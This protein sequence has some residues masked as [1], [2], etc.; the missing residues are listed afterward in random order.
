MKWGPVEGSFRLGDSVCARKDLTWALE[1]T[2]VLGVGTNARQY[3]VWSGNTIMYTH[4][5]SGT[6][7]MLGS[8]YRRWGAI[9]QI[10]SGSGS[11]RVAGKV[12]GTS[13][14]DN[15]AP[16]VNGSV[17]RMTRT[18]TVTVNFTGAGADTALPSSFFTNVVH[19]SPDVNADTADGTFTV[20]ESKAYVLTARVKLSAAVYAWCHLNL[21]VY[22]GSTWST[23]QNGIS[24][25]PDG[26][27]VSLSATFIQYLDAGQK[28]RIATNNA[29]STVSVL[30][31]ESA[32]KETYFAI[33]GAG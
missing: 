12:G 2:F 26:S 9:A 8:G 31:G 32:G 21:Q 27:G 23:V 5:E 18:S 3:Q 16:A 24:F 6:A 14:A 30:T 10:R 7:S 33:T 29:G 15:E 22:N 1:M 11:P 13:V 17:A 20:T 19:E 4:T 28:V 25:Y